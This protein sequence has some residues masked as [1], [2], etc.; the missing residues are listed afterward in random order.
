MKF[1]K[2]SLFAIAAIALVGCG[3]KSGPS[4]YDKDGNPI[5]DIPENTTGGGFGGGSEIKDGDLTL[6]NNA[7]GDAVSRLF[8]SATGTWKKEAIMTTVYFGFDQY[9]VDTAERSKLLTVVEAAKH[10]QLIV[11]GYTDHYGTDQYNLGLSDKRAQSV[12]SYLVKLGV[13]ESNVQIQAYGKQYAKPNGSK[14][15]VREDRRVDIVNANYG[16]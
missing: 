8:D 2:L 4:G 11:A 1:L 13:P 15:E 16:K 14:S 5:L 10:T 9:N 7:A 6:R 12:K 3:P